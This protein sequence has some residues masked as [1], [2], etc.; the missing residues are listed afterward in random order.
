MIRHIVEFTLTSDDESRRAQDADGIREHLGALLGQ[1][2]GL[3]SITVAR[4]L[5]LV[6][7][8]WDVVLISDH[9]DNAAL[10]GYQAHPAHKEASAW[11]STVVSG[12]AIVDF[13]LDG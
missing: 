11:I 9:D 12:R 10:E 5:G 2:P 6:A 1:I 7:G 3:R 13:E 8:H 4:D